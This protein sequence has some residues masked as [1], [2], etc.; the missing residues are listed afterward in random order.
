MREFSKVSPTVWR[1]RK[2]KSLTDTE[3]KFVYFYIL[4]SPHN[5]SAGCYDLHPLYASADIGLSEIQYLNCIDTLSKANLIEFDKDENTVMVVNWETFN[6]PMNPKHAL[7]LLYQLNQASSMRLKAFTFNKFLDIFRSKGFD[8]NP[9]LANAID[10][11]S[12]EYQYH[13]PTKTETKIETENRPDLDKTFTDT[14][15]KIEGLP[16]GKSAIAKG[17]G[18]LPSLTK[19]GALKKK[20]ETPYLKGKH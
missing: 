20:L 17:H 10:T 14:S 9:A 18:V 1:S 16:N 13:L 12:I 15:D 8:A 11:L 19:E 4:T 2:F 5:N 7:G 3:T 6:E